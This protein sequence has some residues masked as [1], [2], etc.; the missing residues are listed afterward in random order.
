MFSL[1][2]PAEYPVNGITTSPSSAV[3]DL[4]SKVRVTPSQQTGFTISHR[5]TYNINCAHSDVEIHKLSFE[6]HKL[7]F[8]IS[9]RNSVRASDFKSPSATKTFLIQPVYP[10]WA[11]Q[12]N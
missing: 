5:S 9:K 6:I 12:C 2:R 1:K 3:H 8:D 7:S 4:L 10:G 11:L